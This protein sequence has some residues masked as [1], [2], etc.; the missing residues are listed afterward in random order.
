MTSHFI[1]LR[2][3]ASRQALARVLFC[4]CVCMC[5]RVCVRAVTTALLAAIFKQTFLFHDN[6]SCCGVFALSSKPKDRIVVQELCGVVEQMW[7]V[8]TRCDDALFSLADTPTSLP[9]ANAA[10]TYSGRPHTSAFSNTWRPRGHH[11]HPPRT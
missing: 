7:T 3:Q 11:Q 9:G 2:G 1:E 10:T 8:S 6:I 5:V 4:V